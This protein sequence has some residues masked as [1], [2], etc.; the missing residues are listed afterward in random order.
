[1]LKIEYLKVKDLNPYKNNSRTHSHAQINQLSK[2]IKEFGFTN[3][4]LIDENNG[5]IAGHGRL[6]A[7]DKASISDVPC[8]RLNGLTEAQRKAYIIAD[9]S[10]ALN[11]DWD[12]EKLQIEVESLKDLDFNIDFLDLDFDDLG[13]DFEDE[14]EGLTDDDSVP[15]KLC[16]RFIAP[17]FSV[18]DTRQGYWQERKKI[19]KDLIGDNGESRIGVL[20]KTAK[21]DKFNFNAIN[22]GV[23]LLDPVL[24]DLVNKWFGLDNC[25]TFDPFAGDSVFGYV[26]NYLGNSFTGIELRQEQVDLNN[27]RIEG[28]KSKYICDDGQNILKHIKANSQDLLFSCPPYFNLE[29]YS[30]LDNDAS[31]QGTY[32]DFIKIIDKAFTD[33]IKCLKDNRFAVVVV[34][35]VRDN[36]GFYYGIAED[37]KAIFKKAGCH[38]YNELILLEIY[39]NLALR[40]GRYMEH[41][42]VGKCHQ[43]VLVFFKGDP[44]E[45]KNIYKK[46]DFKDLTFDESTD[47]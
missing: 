10:I 25:K 15:E 38:L 43:N 45:I 46:L 42:K 31:N 1:M 14:Q 24:S 16:D 40:V 28:D 6:L 3:P 19:W 20:S 41:R 32:A 7:C 39:G 22:N 13:I 18:L 35:D 36:K 8:V 21:K 27:E 5:V 12:I 34:G 26:S 2:S 29:V 4:V 23:S 37:I 11:S 33:S 44:K 17:P 9:N 30:N 47:I